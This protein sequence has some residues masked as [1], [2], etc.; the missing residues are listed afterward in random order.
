MV[1][2]IL[3]FEILI[4]KHVSSFGAEMWEPTQHFE[5]NIPTIIRQL[6]QTTTIIRHLVWNIQI[7]EARW[8]TFQHNITFYEP[9]LQKISMNSLLRLIM[10]N[11]TNWLLVR[12]QRLSN[13]YNPHVS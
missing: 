11:K 3:I 1:S 8:L 4:E 7:L 9:T 10:E 2:G 13:F 6:Y 12:K 5:N